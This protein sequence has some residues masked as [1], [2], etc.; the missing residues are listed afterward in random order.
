M[1]GTGQCLLCGGGL[2]TGQVAVKDL[3]YQ[4]K[5]GLGLLGAGELLKD[6]EQCSHWSEPIQE[7][8]HWRPGGAW[9]LG[10]EA[11]GR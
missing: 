3:K 4:A 11:G 7:A 10:G 8:G 6:C 1:S 2:K 5:S 9:A